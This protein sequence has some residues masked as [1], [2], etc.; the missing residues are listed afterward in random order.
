MLIVRRP[1][2]LCFLVLTALL[3]SCHSA[4]KAP[5]RIGHFTE[6]QDY[7]DKLVES[8]SPPGLSF[9][10]VKDD[11]VVYSRGVGWADEPRGLLATPA[12][13]Y[14]WWSCTKI[15]TAIAV[16]QLQEKGKLSLSDPVI[17]HLPFFEV[18][19]PRQES[20]VITILNLLNHSSGLPDPSAL[21]LM[22]WIH[23]HGETSLNQTDFV[24]NVLPDYSRLRFEP[25]ERAE[26][27][28]LGYMVLGAIIESAA[29]ISYEDY[30]RLNILQPL[31]MNH[32]DFVYTR[33]MEPDEAAGS[34]PL[35]NIMTP[36][37]P[38][39][40][41]SYIRELEGA[42]IWM[43]RVYTDQTPPSGLIGSVTDAARLV[44]AYLNG[45]VLDG[46]R[47]LSEKSVAL[48]TYD[49]QIKDS[50]EDSSDFRRQGIGWQIFGRT[51]RRV[52]TH[53][54]GGPGFSTKIQLYPDEHLGFVLFT[55]DATIEPWK[56]MRLASQLK[57]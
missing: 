35:W 20:K 41:A 34:H 7:L 17:H 23:H 57:W 52:L 28:N 54:G 29:G 14:H 47:I 26:Y 31:G 39:V 13:A 11:T 46:H 44:A 42:H 36:L 51:G 15:A 49:G 43:E 6:F 50:M 30:I 4:P 24:R 55:N 5:E 32:T 48:M 22:S 2:Y 9:A 33:S 16:L 10:V 40:A 18:E 38:L 45:G 8:G 53:D 37:L 27:S 21:T 12:T 56:I 3:C 25:G 19:Y 1:S